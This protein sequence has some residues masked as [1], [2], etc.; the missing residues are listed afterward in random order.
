MNSITDRRA[1]SPE[2][3]RFRI[4]P[5]LMIQAIAWLVAVLLAYGAISAR[6]AVVETR[7]VEADR[8]QSESERRMERIEN[9]LDMLL[10][11]VP[12]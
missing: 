10:S 5:A 8:R 3:D 7:Q 11:R 4:A 6:L 1:D 2:P 12:R 9:K